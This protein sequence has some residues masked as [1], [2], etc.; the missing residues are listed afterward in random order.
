MRPNKI[1]I[2]LKYFKT[3][4]S[5]SN[6]SEETV[7]YIEPVNPVNSILFC[8]TDLILDSSPDST[9]KNSLPSVSLICER[10]SKCIDFVSTVQTSSKS[11]KKLFFLRKVNNLSCNC[12]KPPLLPIPEAPAINSQE[13]SITQI[14]LI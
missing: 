4:T 10:N 2:N 11:E 12:S 5:D 6:T 14:R 9:E 3:D 7:H 13:L 8:D 1:E